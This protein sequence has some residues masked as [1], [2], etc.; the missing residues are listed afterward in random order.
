[1]G[2]KGYNDITSRQII[3][4]KAYPGVGCGIVKRLGFSGRHGIVVHF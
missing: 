2:G 3:L 1:M 4:Q